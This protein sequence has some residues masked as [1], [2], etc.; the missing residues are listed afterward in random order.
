M[1]NK[2]R[3]S[4][5]GSGAPTAITP[6]FL[7][8]IYIDETSGTRYEATALTKGS[9]VDKLSLKENAANKKTSLTDNSDT[10]YPT[11]KAVK[12]AVDAKQDALGFTPEN[13]ANKKTTIT[14]SDI[15]YPTCKA[16]NTGLSGKQNTLGFTPENVANKKTSLADNSDTYY[17]SQ[18]AVKTAVDAKAPSASPTF[19]GTVTLPKAVNIKDTSADHEYQL[20]VSELAANRTV[21]LPLL[22]GND[23]FMFKDFHKASSSEIN[24]GTEDNKYVTPDAL[25]GSN[26]FTKTVQQY[27]VEWGT[28]LAVADGVG[29]IIIPAECN[30]MNLISARADVI[31]AG[32]INAS[33]FDIYNV[34]DSTTMLSSAISIASGATSGTGTVDTAH[35]D[36]ATGDI[37][38]IDCDS[39]STTPPKGLIV[40][41]SF[42][43]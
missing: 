24:T 4:K 40:T 43:L 14:D 30:G 22:T 12:T 39:I 25:A 23:T 36:V 42:R 15:D 9:W 37:I 41:L 7:G 18:K 16:V 19:T 21:T 34:T 6:D 17:P 2:L 35:D 31:T 5:S 38:R 32:T 11:Q 28:E 1:A 20:G 10:Y 27:C 8:Q 13:V 29:Y 33:T 3:V 26:A